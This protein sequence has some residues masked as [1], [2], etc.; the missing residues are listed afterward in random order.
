MTGVARSIAF[1]SKAAVDLFF[2][3]AY[4][5]VTKI[6]E[7]H[8]GLGPEGSSP[9]C[10]PCLR[11]GQELRLQSLQRSER[12]VGVQLNEEHLRT[13][14]D[15][16]WRQRP[17][18]HVSPRSRAAAAGDHPHAR[19]QRRALCPACGRLEL[20]VRIPVTRAGDAPDAECGDL[21]RCARG[22]GRRPAGRAC[23][24]DADDRLERD[25]APDQRRLR[26]LGARWTTSEDA[27][28]TDVE[29]GGA[30]RRVV[31]RKL[32]AVLSWSH[33]CRSAHGR[34]RS[35]GAGHRATA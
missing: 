7:D 8:E 23:D 28:R 18:R 14:V 17:V 21:Y 24:P 5:E 32:R 34:S 25:V 33:A 26:V 6:H 31:P 20:D 3:T 9:S 2:A 27:P 35:G 19:G 15:V 13:R 29:G 1:R 4:H 11:D 10:S 22:A 16:A 12:R 30:R